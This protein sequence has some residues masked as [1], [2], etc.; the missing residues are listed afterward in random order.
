MCHSMIF[1]R[2]WLYWVAC[3]VKLGYVRYYN[4]WY[5]LL[6]QVA[7]ATLLDSMRD[8]ISF[9]QKIDIIE[10]FDF[11]DRPKNRQTDRQTK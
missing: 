1:I 10:I 4:R 11:S 2:A 6:Y 8:Y 7:C 9:S 5:A 3:A